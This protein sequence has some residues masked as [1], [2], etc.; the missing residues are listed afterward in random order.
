[1]VQVLH[2]MITTVEILAAYCDRPHT[3]SATDAHH[4]CIVTNLLVSWLDKYLFLLRLHALE[5][6]VGEF[7]SRIVVQYL[8]IVLV[9][10]L[11]LSYR[12]LNYI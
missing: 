3:S 6:K 2:K 12:F 7:Q 4:I 9:Y 8:F 5:L 1:M 10:K 11:E